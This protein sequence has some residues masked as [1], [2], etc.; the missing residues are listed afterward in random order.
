MNNVFK[1]LHFDF[2]FKQYTEE[3]QPLNNISIRN[4]VIKK[5]SKPNKEKCDSINLYKLPK[6][7]DREISDLEKEKVNIINKKSNVIGFAFIPK[8]EGF[9]LSLVYVERIFRP[10][11][12]RI[13]LIVTSVLED[14][15]LGS[16]EALIYDQQKNL[17]L[18]QYSPKEE[19]SRFVSRI[20]IDDLKNFSENHNNVGVLLIKSIIQIFRETYEGRI[21]LAA[22]ADT[23]T[24]YYKLGFRCQGKDHQQ[25]D[26]AIKD[27]VEQ[28]I[29][30]CLR[31]N[32][33]GM[34][35]PI[36]SRLAWFK[37]IEENPIWLP[38]IRG[39]AKLSL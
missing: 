23:P 4:E 24:Y 8:K 32:L 35:L 26:E 18:T 2:C 27:L 20:F 10:N 33:I 22:L 34:Y 14:K 31:Y 21:E 17:H 3:N 11:S 15:D 29:H 9:D 39:I 12:D 38:Q 5:P 37:E 30:N 6:F 16:V 1:I 7:T 13:Y 19:E 36:E 25:N 28:K